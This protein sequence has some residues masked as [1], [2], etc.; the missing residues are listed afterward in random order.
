MTCFV[1]F[2]LPVSATLS[3]FCPFFP[4]RLSLFVFF[5]PDFQAAAEYLVAERYT[6]AARIAIQGGSNGGL[7][8]GACI[9]QRPELFG[10]AVAQVGVMDML[11]FHRFTIGYA[12]VL[13]R[14]LAC[15]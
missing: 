3:T 12:Y 10:C 1:F 6:T 2:H 14:F 8:V 15:T 9:N 4:S 5:C 13:C 11:K 7:L